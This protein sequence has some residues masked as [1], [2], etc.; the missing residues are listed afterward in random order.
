M[1]RPADAGLRT[2]ADEISCGGR[3]LTEQ[4]ERVKGGK[5]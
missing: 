4:R 5:E 1:K 3:I 2:D